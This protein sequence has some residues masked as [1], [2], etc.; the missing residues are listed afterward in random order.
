MPAERGAAAPAGLPCLNSDNC[1]EPASAFAF[2]R[3]QKPLVVPPS[4]RK[5]ALAL[6]INVQAFVERH[7]IE[8]VGFLTLTF[9]DHVTDPKEAQKRW[10]S[11]R[12]HV[13]AERYKGSIRVFERQKSGR[14]HYH[15]LVA[16]GKDIRTGCDFPAIAKG[17]YRSA[18]Q[19]LREEWTYWRNAAKDY[20]F[21]RTELLPIKSS[22]EAVSR[23]VGKYIS[24]HIEARIDCDKGVRLVEYSHHSRI[25]N[26]RFAWVSPGAKLW[27]AK[28]GG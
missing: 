14:I 7:G 20:R 16:T 5:T 19:A 24:K 22:A 4:A 10:H 21:G 1:T 25:A 15:V 27:R 18:N 26:T 2:N 17:D 3:A 8:T 9:K 12:T 11:L 28:L 6:S 13:L 23:Y